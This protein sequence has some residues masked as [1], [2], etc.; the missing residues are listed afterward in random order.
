MQPALPPVFA[1]ERAMKVGQDE[2]KVAGKAAKIGA[3][4]KLLTPLPRAPKVRVELGSLGGRMLPGTRMISPQMARTIEKL[5]A[6]RQGHHAEASRLGTV[7]GEAQ[8]ADRERLNQRLIALLWQELRAELPAGKPDAAP[9]VLPPSPAPWA[10]PPATAGGGSPSVTTPKPELRA[11]LA[12]ELIEKIER[13]MRSG[14]PALAL[15]LSGLEARVEIER[16]GS[17]EVALTVLGRG[18]PLP[19]EELGRIRDGI[20][21]RGLT[22]RSLTLA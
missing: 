1:E 21:A 9:A 22:L 13:F 7:R 2:P 19:E 6:V 12:I 18:R 15:T 8:G 3:F 16:T 5:A 4:E 14:R 11:A 17:Q 20:R 10:S